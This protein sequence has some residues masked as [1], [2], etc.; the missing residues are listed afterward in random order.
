MFS[1][2]STVSFNQAGENMSLLMK[3]GILITLLTLQDS[4]C[5]WL[6]H[7]Q[8]HLSPQALQVA[9]GRTV[10]HCHHSAHLMWARWTGPTEH[11]IRG[12]C[13]PKIPDIN[14]SYSLAMSVQEHLSHFTLFDWN[15]MHEAKGNPYNF[16]SPTTPSLG[17]KLCIS[18]ASLPVV[19]GKGFRLLVTSHIA[20]LSSFCLSD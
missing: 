18:P 2:F 4:Q 19:Q 13:E 3:D 1:V 5:H 14:E 16:C 6:S 7:R 12:R 15:K 8:T 17:L 20:H 11:K 10:H 9:S